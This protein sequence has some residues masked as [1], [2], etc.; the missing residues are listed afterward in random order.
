MRPDWG[1][2]LGVD[3]L[4]LYMPLLLPFCCSCSYVNEIKRHQHYLQ[5]LHKSGLTRKMIIIAAQQSSGS[6][7]AEYLMDMGVYK[8][9][10]KMFVLVDKMRSDKR[11]SMQKFAYNLRRNPTFSRKLL[12]QGERV[13]T[14]TGISWAGL[15]DCNPFT[16]SVTAD[17]F[18]NYAEKALVHSLI[19]KLD[20][21]T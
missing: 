6:L 4:G 1:N 13:S 8:G 21:P 9:H 12:V 2:N 15:L 7:R 19:R 14:T 17:W 10:P 5:V 20:L 18:K 16:G 11:D 3:A